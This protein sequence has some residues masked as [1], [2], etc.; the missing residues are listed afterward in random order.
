MSEIVAAGGMD[1]FEAARQADAD[2]A[3]FWSAR[4]LAP[5][6]GYGRWERFSLTV[7]R[8]RIACD[9]STGDPEDHFRPSS[10]MVP[11]GS[12]ASRALPDWHLTR[13]AA[14]LVAMNGDPRKE[15]IAQAQAYFAV[16]TSAME[17]TSAVASTMRRQLEA[18]DRAT[19][20]QQRITALGM[21]KQFGV[22]N[23]SYLEAL[24]R[25][26]LA[27][28]FGQEPDLEPD[29]HTLACYDYLEEKGVRGRDL[30]RAGPVLGKKVAARYRARYGKEPQKGKRPI[31]GMHRPVGI[32]TER[33]RDLFDTA[34]GEMAHKYN[35]QLRVIGN[36]GAS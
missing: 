18:V 19:V 30:D 8:G 16:Q 4:D 29:Q 11:V 6:M 25:L 22:V 31:H 5:I 1:P 15:E 33:D 36:G 34:W 27:R 13:H 9:N 12:G 28:M 10:K 21:A 17:R 14:Y 23:D 20:A 24:G 26:E 32:Y 2:G 3:D 7:D 35:V